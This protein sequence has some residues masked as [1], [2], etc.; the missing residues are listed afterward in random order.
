MKTIRKIVS[1]ASLL[2]LGAAAPRAFGLTTSQ[3]YIESYRGRTD[4][5][6]PVKIVAPDADASLV[7]AHVQV[8][9]LVDT[10]GRPQAVR[11]LSATDPDFARAVREAVKLWRF[12]P[13]RPNGTPVPM[14]VELPVVVVGQ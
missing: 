7:G 11:V 10:A 2:A 8:E 13:A 12:A 14:K 5:P 1:L 6:A 4:V 3:A 9:F